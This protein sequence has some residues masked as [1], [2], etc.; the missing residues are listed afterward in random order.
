M[1]E[2]LTITLVFAAMTT[3]SIVLLVGAFVG[4]A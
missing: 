1:T 3:G 2:I 4:E